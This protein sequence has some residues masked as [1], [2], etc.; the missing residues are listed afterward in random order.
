M[1]LIKDL[2]GIDYDR[3]VEYTRENYRDIKKM[4]IEEINDMLLLSAFTFDET[5]EEEH[6]WHSVNERINNEKQ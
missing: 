6:Y 1:V 4:S 2:E 3:A 5:E